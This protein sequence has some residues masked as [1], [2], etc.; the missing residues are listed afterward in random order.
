MNNQDQMKSMEGNIVNWINSLKDEIINLK[1]IVIRNLQDKNETLWCR[2]ERLEERC[3]KY[4]SDHN[5][6][7]QYGQ[8]NNVVLSGISESV[9]EDVLEESVISVLAV[10]E[11]FVESEDTE[12]CHR[13]GKPDREKSQ[14]TIV[15]LVNRK[16]YKK[17]LFNKK[18]LNSI[19]CSKHNFTQNTKIFSNENLTPMN[20][21]IAYNCRKLKQWFHSWLLLKRWHCQN[22]MPGKR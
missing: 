19:D 14:K 6:L 20:E 3:S 18:K 17:V 12:V 9:S 2:C 16:N 4:E 7:T 21:S 15:H 13:F 1:E 11:V 8:Q 22:Q 10:I 5:A